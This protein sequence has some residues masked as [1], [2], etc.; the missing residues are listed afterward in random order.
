MPDVSL[1]K[2]VI[3]ESLDGSEGIY[4]DGKL[5]AAGDFISYSDFVRVLQRHG[6]VGFDFES[7][8]MRQ[9]LDDQV[10]ESGV[11]PVMLPQNW[12]E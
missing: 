9:E 3:A 11:F 2:V 10:Q 4:V 12:R 7:G 6:L 8:F 1:P 5:V